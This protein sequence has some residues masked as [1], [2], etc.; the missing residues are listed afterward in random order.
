[1]TG[2]HNGTS[3]RL[4][5]LYDLISTHDTFLVIRLFQLLGQCIFTYGTD[6]DDVFGR[7][8]VGCCSCSVLGCSAGDVGYLVVF[9]DVVVAAQGRGAKMRRQPTHRHTLIKQIDQSKRATHMPICFS[10]AKMAS[11]AFKLYFSNKA[12][13]LLTC[14]SSKGLPM[15][16]KRGWAGASDI[17]GS[18]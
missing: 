12:S 9:G 3:T 16:N 1:M 17:L 18:W 8:D 14:M 2:Q 4:V 6:V 13:P 5:I 11:L 15:Q 7:K 10:S